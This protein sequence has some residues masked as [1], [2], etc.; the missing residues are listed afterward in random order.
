[1]VQEKG[2]DQLLAAE[3]TAAS[4]IGALLGV[5]L[6]AASSPVDGATWLTFLPDP[7]L[8][9]GVAPAAIPLASCPK[10]WLAIDSPVLIPFT[11]DDAGRVS[12]EAFPPQELAGFVRLQAFDLV[13]CRSS[14]PVTQNL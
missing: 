4:Q 3:Q 13:S 1:M 12:L 11:T 10:A 14:L 8:R 2:R 9:L 7:R 5:E 6:P